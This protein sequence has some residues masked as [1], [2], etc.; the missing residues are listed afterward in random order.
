MAAFYRRMYARRKDD[1]KRRVKEWRGKNR[2]RKR[3]NDRTRKARLKG[4]NGAHT[5][6]DVRRQYIAQDGRC[7]W[8]RRL[9]GVDYPSFHVDHLIPLNRG[10]TNWPWNIVLACPRCNCARHDK[11]PLE[12]APYYLKLPEVMAD[13]PT[14]DAPA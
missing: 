13:A 9:V 7:F 2:Q 8:C 1:Y 4:T 12:W 10:G 6:A 3:A 14:S 11:M 5:A